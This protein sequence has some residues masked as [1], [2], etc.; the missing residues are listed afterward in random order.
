MYRRLLFLVLLI[1]L[2]PSSVFTQKKGDDELPRGVPILW[3]DPVDI[4]KRNLYWGPGGAAEKPDLSKVTL[5]K[6]ETGGY[7][8]K[9]RVRD[10]SGREWVAKVGKEAQAETSASRL[11]WAVGF[12]ADKNYLVPRVKVEGIP[13]PL[14]NARFSLRPDHVKRLDGW[15]WSRNPFSGSKQFQ[16]LKVMMALL[17]NWDIKDDNNKINVISDENGGATELRYFVADLGG[18]FGKSS[19][20]PVIWRFTRS[21]NNLRDYAKAYFVDLVRDGIVYFE[22]AGKQ[23]DLFEDISVSDARWMGSLLS[24]LSKR[25]LEDAFRASNYTQPQIRLLTEAVQ[26]RIA[27]LNALPRYQQIAR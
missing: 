1:A 11:L 2:V 5:I 16:G 27:E 21:R 8:T 7:S 17:N 19:P 3:R 15:K 25:Q 12:F 13:G 10:G 6:K 22:F 9:Y 26:D 24:R 4:S 23:N 14:E 20:V 18:T